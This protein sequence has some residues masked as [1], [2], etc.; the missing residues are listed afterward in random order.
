MKLPKGGDGKFHINT[1][2]GK[3]YPDFAVIVGENDK[4]YMVFEVKDRATFCFDC[5][6]FKA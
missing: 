2:I 4:L 5:R 1:P 3:Y 6:Y